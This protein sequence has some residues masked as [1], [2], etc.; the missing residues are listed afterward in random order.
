M[1]SQ[2]SL[3]DSEGLRH[4]SDVLAIVVEMLDTR[5]QAQDPAAGRN[6]DSP[7]FTGVKALDAPFPCLRQ[8]ELTV[9]TGP[10]G[11]GKTSLASQI[12]CHAAIVLKRSVLFYTLGESTLRATRY[13]LSAQGAPTCNRMLTGNMDE[14]HWD[15]FTV[16]LGKL[17][18]APIHLSEERLN[19]PLLYEEVLRK[20]QAVGS[21]RR[22]LLIVDNVESLVTNV[23]GAD[24]CA[25][26]AYAVRVLRELAVEMGMPVLLVSQWGFDATP[27]LDTAAGYRELE[28][29]IL[30]G[31]AHTHIELQ[32]SESSE[33]VGTNVVARIHQGSIYGSTNRAKSGVIRQIR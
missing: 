31:Q 8:G 25:L 24:R 4:L 7:V 1:N 27:A 22:R 26:V 14:D 11:I 18:D 15:Q 16:A 6:E 3:T 10:P 13:M 21:R 33:P 20:V 5:Y 17:H 23:S 28:N 30:L 9:L 29:R 2:D 32:W 19:A 12:S